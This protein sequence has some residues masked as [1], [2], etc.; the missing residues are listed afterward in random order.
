MSGREIR[1]LIAEVLDCMYEKPSFKNVFDN[2]S[3]AD[4]EAIENEIFLIIKRR[5]EDKLK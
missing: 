4:T 3:D 2:L 1:K 5:I